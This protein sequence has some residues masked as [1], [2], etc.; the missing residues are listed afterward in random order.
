[1]SNCLRNI[2]IATFISEQLELFTTILFENFFRIDVLL[3]LYIIIFY[4]HNILCFNVF[5]IL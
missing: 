4:L 5:S 3:F 2:R 1:M